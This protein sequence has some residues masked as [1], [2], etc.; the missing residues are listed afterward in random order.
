[1]AGTENETYRS[2]LTYYDNTDGIFNELILT[3]ITILSFGQSQL[4]LVKSGFMIHR[5]YYFFVYSFH[6][7]KN[8]L[9]KKERKTK[10][11][12]ITD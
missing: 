3:F 9:G 4:F 2:P 1:M 7:L 6:A 10:L 11:S 8:K 5:I 12:L